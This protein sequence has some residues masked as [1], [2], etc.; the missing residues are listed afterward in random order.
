MAQKCFILLPLVLALSAAPA[1]AGTP[2]PAPDAAKAAPVDTQA[3]YATAQKPAELRLA[4][5]TIIT[6]RGPLLGRPPVERAA[7]AQRLLAKLLDGPPPHRV[8]TRPVHDTYVVQVNDVAVFFVTPVDADALVGETVESVA[9]AAAKALDK[10]I[11][12]GAEARSF[13]YMLKAGGY[14]AAGTAVFLLVLWGLLRLRRLL[15]GRVLALAHAQA[16][17]LKIGD[18]ELVD[19]DVALRV[20]RTAINATFWVL[21]LVLAHEYLGFVLQQFP[22]TRALGERMEGFLVQTLL[23]MGE[24][25]VGALPDL[26]IAV[27]IFL[28]ARFIAGI[29]R[30][31]FDRVESGRAR[32]GWLDRETVRPT[33]RL[34]GAVIWIFALV[35]AYP[36]LPGAETDAFKGMSVL[37]GLMIS[38]GASSVV[39]QAASGVILMYTRTI[40]QGEYVRIGEHEGTVMEIGMFTT[41]I[42]TGMG[43]ELNLPSALVVSSVTKNYSR[44]VKGQGFIVDTTVTIGYDTPWRQVEAML[45]EAARRTPGVVADPAPRVFQVALSDFYPEYRLAC[46]AVPSEPMPRAQVMT[47]LHANIQDVF[48]EH[49]VQIMSPHY[50]GDPAT[51]KIVPQDQWYAAPA[52]PPKKS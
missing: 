37:L 20:A 50:L 48:N 4:N 38:L 24:S 39:G 49:G 29:S 18:A 7:T 42:R 15:A 2:P 5:R 36:Y 34:V 9:G 13:E 33:R 35:M 14:A 23:G 1:L 40:R 52:Q 11:A 16:R 8:G 28:I 3:D 45:V 30:R 22:Y 47:M 27:L 26:I 17:Q 21:V 43:E 19:R 10:A 32:L 41:R 44:T 46:Q 31:F 51:T 6:F 25:I 12:E